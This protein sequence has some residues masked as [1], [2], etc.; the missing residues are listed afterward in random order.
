MRQRFKYPVKY[1]RHALPCRTRNRDNF[2]RASR[3]QLRCYV[4]HQFRIKQ[5][6]FVERYNLR[7]VFKS[8]TII[9]QLVTYRV[10]R[11]HRIILRRVDQMD[12]DLAALFR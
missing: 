10:P 3:L 12:E 1:L 5:I 9:G 11:L 2:L 8:S 7:F 4:R 6:A